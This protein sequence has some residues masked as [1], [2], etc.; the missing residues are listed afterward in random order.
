MSKFQAAQQRA[1]DDLQ[2]AANRAIGEIYNA[3]IPT[4]DSFSDKLFAIYDDLT[5]EDFERMAQHFGEEN[6]IEFINRMERRKAKEEA[7][8]DA[9]TKK[10][11]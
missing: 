10:P 6:I 11:I 8:Q 5:D 1:I 9:Q 7:E 2:N 4:E 3:P